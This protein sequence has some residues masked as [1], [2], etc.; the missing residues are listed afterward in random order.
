MPFYDSMRNMMNRQDTFLFFKKAHWW[1]VIFCLHTVLA[2]SGCSD[3]EIPPSAAFDKPLYQW[4]GI[5]GQTITVR[6]NRAD[7][8]RPYMVKAFKRY[9][10][11]TGNTIQL[12]AVNHEEL[13]RGLRAAFDKNTEEKP[14]VVVTPG[15]TFLDNLSP[16]SNFYDFTN[17]PWVEDLT[18]T[19]INQAIYN[20]R[21]IGLPHSEA[22]VSGTLYNKELFKK[23]G[24]E[25]PRTQAEFLAVCETLLR[26][27]VTP[28][29]LPYAERSMMLYQF[30]LDSV[31]YNPNIL[32]GLNSGT[33]SYAELPEMKK[34]VSWYKIMAD[35]G[36]LGHE[37]T[38][39][40]WSGMNEAMYSE[41]YAMMLCWDTWLYTDFTGDASRFGIMP[42][43]MGVPDE[44][45]FEGPNQMLLVVNKHSPRLDVALDL[46]TFMADP[47]NYNVAFE[48]MYTAPVFKNQA[49]SL[50]T[51]QYMRAERLIEKRFFDSIAWPRI[52]G[53]SQ[54]DAEYIQTHMQNSTY[55]VEDCLRDMD[56]AR[57]R[58]IQNGRTKH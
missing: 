33:L 58:R 20:A 31:V 57:I 16:D 17:A 26:N 15:G 10:T 1:L 27:G 29:Y 36:Y 12:E 9:E 18:D 11:L 49:G 46:I 54:L 14:D 35:R 19:A 22:S 53:F 13:A 38:S 52:R 5:T 56:A 23:F 39:N 4:G 50:S 32:E 48:G 2:L 44:G 47:F 37:Y 24:I 21:V 6:G 28:L 40:N 3:S 25:V 43:F 51:P 7:L 34:I 30:P 45:A 41:Q 8:Y 42:V 55:T